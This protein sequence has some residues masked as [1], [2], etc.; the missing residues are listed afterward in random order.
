MCHGLGMRRRI[1]GS[2]G[3]DAPYV[4]I[5]SAVAAAG[6]IVLAILA[7]G[8]SSTIWWL[9]W[10]LVIGAQAVVYMY[11]TLRGKFAIWTALVDQQR[12]DGSEAVLDVG[13]GRGMVL[14]TTALALKDGKATGIDLWRSRDQS[15]NDPAATT[16]N[17]ELNGVADRIELQTADMTELPFAD[18][19]FDAVTANVA[20]QNVKDRG[21]RRQTISEIYRVTKPSGRILI[22]DIQYVK[23]YRDDLIACGAKD[24]T[25]KRLGIRGWFGNPFFASKLVSAHKP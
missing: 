19:S 10:A 3:I 20:I 14:I 4:P 21:L 24:V 2:Y 23:E 8:T 12:F 15:G 6:C 16:A 7:K 1:K 5:I 13:C 25:V 11:T 17:A 22:T 18:A 9:A